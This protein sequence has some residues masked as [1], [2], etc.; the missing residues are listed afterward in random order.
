MQDTV[1]IGHIVPDTVCNRCIEW[2]EESGETFATFA[3]HASGR[4]RCSAAAVA[5]STPAP[6][7]INRWPDSR[8]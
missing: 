3:A 6:N 7:S 1:C 4:K 8:S 2:S 5:N